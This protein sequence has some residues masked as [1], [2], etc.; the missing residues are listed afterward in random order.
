MPTTRKEIKNIKNSLKSTNLWLWWNI[1]KLLKSSTDYISVPVSYLSNQP[2]AAEAFPDLLKY[3]NV[4]PLYK[5]GEKSCK[6]NY[7]PI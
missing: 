5:K 1:T 3:S 6:L 4:N 2:I 7:R